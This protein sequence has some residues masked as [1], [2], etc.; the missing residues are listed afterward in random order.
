VGGTESAT[1]VATIGTRNLDTV[2]SLKDG[3]TS[4]IGGLISDNKNVNK[5][6]IFL[7]G[8]I[9][10]LGELF[11]NNNTT[12]DKSELIFAITPRLIRGVMIP[13]NSLTSFVSGKE[14]DPTLVRPQPP[15]EEPAVTGVPGNG[16][17]QNEQLKPAQATLLP[18]P[19]PQQSQAI[20]PTLPPQQPVAAPSVQNQE[21]AASV[22]SDS[23]ED[24][25]QFP[26]TG[27]MSPDAQQQNGADV[28]LNPSASSAPGAPVPSP[29]QTPVQRGSLQFLTPARLIPGQDFTLEVKVTDVKDL[30]SAPFTVTYDPAFVT[31]VSASEG[32][33]LKRGGGATTFSSSNEAVSGSLTINNSRTAGTGGVSGSGTLASL[34]FRAKANKG[35]AGFGFSN[36]NFS[37]V[38]GTPHP[39]LPFNTAIEIK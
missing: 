14:D 5:Q 13:Q 17:R 24:A 18:A 26:S 33:F 7:L 15:V 2:L 3:E 39:M 4:I 1:V 8:E 28:Q 36:V 27:K 32:N 11:S 34:V 38:T 12:K 37:T 30:F 25:S 31:F 19:L 9:P 29:K 20:A 21:S 35:G 23:E 16:A 10:L 6:K 22:P